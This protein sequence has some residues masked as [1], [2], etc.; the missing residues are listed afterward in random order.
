MAETNIGIVGLGLVGRA[1]AAFL[2]RGGDTVAGCDVSPAACAQALAEG[3][4]VCADLDD[5]ARRCGTLVLCVLDDA[6]LLAVVGTLACPQLARPDRLVVNCV[7]CS[8][9]A[10]DTTARALGAI[11]MPLSGSSEQVRNG[12]ALGL[13]GATDVAWSKHAALLQRLCP[14]T[15]RVGGPGAGARAKLAC[16]LVLGLNR[17]AL[18]EGL[19]LAQR[20]GLEGTT[21]VDLLRE[22][23][24]YSRAVDTAAPRML[25]RHFSSPGSRINQ[26]RKDLALIL[27]EAQ[28][29]GLDLPLARG[30][31]T[32]L[33]RA[34]ARGLGELDN[35][36]VFAALDCTP[37]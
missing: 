12:G 20:L 1:L 30:Q 7:T 31:T 28:A 21:F 18:A 32:L 36:A 29:A 35:A 2:S 13:V 26:H 16:N 3:V 27:A 11:D 34:I 15:V 33:D 23:P 4:A 25:Q 19:A 6:A 10:A 17:S 8:P 9:L 5:L 22:S 24:A 14:R 37:P